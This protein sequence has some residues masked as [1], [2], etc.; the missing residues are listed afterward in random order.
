MKKLNIIEKISI[1]IAYL[2]WLFWLIGFCY[3][4]ISAGKEGIDL[5]LGTFQIFK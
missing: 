1:I 4:M 5:D 3:I 2:I